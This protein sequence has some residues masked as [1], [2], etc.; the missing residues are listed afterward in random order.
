MSILYR[1]FV[2]AKI[3]RVL[4]KFGRVDVLVNNAATFIFGTVEEVTSDKWDEVLSV[5][6]KGYAFT[7]KHV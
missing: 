5:N 3:F 7:T 2:F 4:Q 6:I 1:K